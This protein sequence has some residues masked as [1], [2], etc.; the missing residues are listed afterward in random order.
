[1]HLRESCLLMF[2]KTVRCVQLSRTQWSEIIY[3]SPELRFKHLLILT[4][5]KS[6]PFLHE[7]LSDLFRLTSF[8][9]DLIFYQVANDLVFQLRG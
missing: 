6:G 5:L 3:D 8:Q 7:Q 1:M 2:A 9:D 4:N